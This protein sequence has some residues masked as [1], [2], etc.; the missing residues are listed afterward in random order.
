MPLVIIKFVEGI[1]DTKLRGKIQTKRILGDMRSSKN[2]YEA[3]KYQLRVM[4]ANSLRQKKN[5]EKIGRARAHAIAHT[6][7]DLMTSSMSLQASVN[8]TAESFYAATHETPI[9][10]HFDYM[11]CGMQMRLHQ[12]SMTLSYQLCMVSKLVAIY[13]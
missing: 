8:T 9:P 13:T 10:K 12:L 5:G 3:S 7:N 1:Q 11:W 2:V 4:K 6:M